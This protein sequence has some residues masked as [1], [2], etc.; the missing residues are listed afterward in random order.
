MAHYLCYIIEKKKS[1][2]IPIQKQVLSEIDML[3]NILLNIGC[4]EENDDIAGVGWR[5]CVDKI[6]SQVTTFEEN[7]LPYLENNSKK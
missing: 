6:F 3:K 7:I 2:M 4:Y 5:C 1:M